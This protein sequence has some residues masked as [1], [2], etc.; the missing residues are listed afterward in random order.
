MNEEPKS[1]RTLNRTEILAIVAIALAIGG[2]AGMSKIN[3]DLSSLNKRVDTIAQN[4]A[5]Q[6]TKT[7]SP[8]DPIT[9]TIKSGKGGFEVT[10]PNGWG[11]LINVKDGDFMIVP[12]QKQP[13]L[14][15]SAKTVVREE[16]G[17][18]TDAA[19]LF[20]ISLSDTADTSLPQGTAEDFTI[21]KEDTALKGKKYTYIFAKDDVE[22]IGYQRFQGDRN[23]RYV[24]TTKTGKALLVDYSVYGS[25]PRNLSEVVDE[26]VRSMRVL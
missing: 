14:D 19:S 5:L 8:N 22:G 3:S 23:Y 6:P 1:K 13:D 20:S 7:Q 17:Y 16:K 15:S 21:G 9:T 12:G 18:G 26:I 24:F 11:P 10:V 2:Y 4:A 25:D